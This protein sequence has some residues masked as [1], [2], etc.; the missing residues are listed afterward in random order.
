MQLYILK[1][2]QISPQ[3]DRLTSSGLISYRSN[4]FIINLCD[5]FKESIKKTKIKPKDICAVLV[6]N[7][8]SLQGY[9]EFLAWKGDFSIPIYAEKSV[10]EEKLYKYL[11]SF[12]VVPYNSFKLAECII[13][14]FETKEGI[15]YRFEN[16]LTWAEAITEIPLESERYFDHVDFVVASGEGI[17]TLVQKQIKKIYSLSQE[18]IGSNSKIEVLQNE[19]NLSLISGAYLMESKE[20]FQLTLAQAE[21]L[22]FGNKK[23]IIQDKFYEDKINKKLYLVSSDLCFG[24]IVLKQPKEISLDHFEDLKDKH[25][26]TDKERR[27]WWGDKRTLFAYPFTFE[28]LTEPKKILPTTPETFLKEITFLQDV[29]V[30]K[31][32]LDYNSNIPTN[33]QLL[34]DMN[35]LFT[36]YEDKVEGKYHRFSLSQIEFLAETIFNEIIKR[37]IDYELTAECKSKELYNLISQKLDNSSQIDLIHPKSFIKHYENIEELLENLK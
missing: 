16:S 26:V 28:R 30:L 7:K 6:T 9:E 17:K 24:F 3:E 23:L 32:P 13:M 18:D 10:R 8:D 5:N 31:T 14:P 35:E 21:L 11:D 37:K 12:I 33:E 20:A 29:S 15:G 36:W 25:K 4:N 1:A 19:M 2:G 34:Q 27:D 22:W